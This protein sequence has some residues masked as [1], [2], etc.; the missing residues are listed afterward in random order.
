[1]QLKRHDDGPWLLVAEAGSW[2]SS[3]DAAVAKEPSP[4]ESRGGGGSSGG[5]S[6]DVL[7]RLMQKREQELSK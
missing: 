4:G 7:K 6:D 3:S 2:G 1:M 5:S